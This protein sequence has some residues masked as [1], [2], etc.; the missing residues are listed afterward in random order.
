MQ[1]IIMYKKGERSWTRYIQ[2][3]VTKANKNFLAVFTGQTG[4]GKTL[5]AVE[6]SLDIDPEF[7]VEQQLAFGFRGVMRIINNF[8]NKDHPLS[9]KKYKIVI[10]DEPQ[11]DLSNRDWQSK[12]NKLFNFLLSTFRH[13]NIIMFFC[14]PYVDFLDSA[15]VKLI[16][17]EFKCKGWN[18]KKKKSI[19]RPVLLQYNSKQ[20]KM[21]EHSLY[22]IKNGMTNKLI[23]LSLGECRK[24]VVIT[25]ERMKNDF[26]NKLNKRILKELSEFENDGEIEVDIARGRRALTDKQLEAMELI[27][28][29]GSVDAAAK[30]LG[31][32]Q[33]SMSDRKLSAEKKGYRV[34][35]FY[36]NNQLRDA[37]N[38]K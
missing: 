16:H 2:K 17:A 23:N 1:N 5:G 18:D 31:I 32:A 36:T 25:Y 35:E 13:Q 12:A 7:D 29:L 37:L 14:L 15:S 3:R 19:I 26:T 27:A 10:F 24:D 6:E 34:S 38:K 30:S 22:V 20:K 8:N 4:I 11:I 28:S 33:P 9:K 21:Y